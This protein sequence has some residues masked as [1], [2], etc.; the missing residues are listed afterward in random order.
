MPKLTPQQIQKQ[1]ALVQ[2]RWEAAPTEKAHPRLG[3]RPGPT[4][5][6]LTGPNS[7]EEAAAQ[8]HKQYRALASLTAAPAY[9]RA[10][11]WRQYN[12]PTLP[13]G[14]YVTDAR[15]QKN[16]GSCVA[17]GTVAA[18]EAAVRIRQ[19]N[20]NLTID[21]AE[22]DLFYCHGGVQP[23][24]TCETGWWPDA[25]LTSC[26]RAG[27]VDE[28]CFPYTP[29]DQPCKKCSDWAKRVTKISRFQ[30]VTATTDMKNLLAKHG[31]LITCM[32]VYEDFFSYAGGVYHHVT[33]TLQGGHCI[34]CV[35]YDEARQA[36]ICKNSWGTG[37]G[38]KGFFRIA[39]GE[40]AIDAS[41]WVLDL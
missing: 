36:W 37:W 10:I 31:P 13:P 9:P 3:Y 28:A 8:G 21:L 18:L 33:G 26:Q 23:G 29:G 2:A 40:C 38:E 14:H 12:G 35:G 30:K 25:A 6:P 41:M 4:N 24:P 19:K 17:F 11:D 5:R 7:R 32:S 27:V 1:L 22:A 15:D 16:C 20:P 34:C 39:Y